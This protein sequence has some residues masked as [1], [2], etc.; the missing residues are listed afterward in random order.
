MS[1]LQ[2]GGWDDVSGETFLRNLLSMPLE[3][4]KWTTVS[5]LTSNVDNFSM[6]EKHTPHVAPLSAASPCQAAV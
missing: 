6:L 4:A 5:P 2:S 3:H 1:I